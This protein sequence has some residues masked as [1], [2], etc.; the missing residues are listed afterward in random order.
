MC[1]GEQEADQ[2]GLTDTSR[3]D[4]SFSDALSSDVDLLAV[5]MSLSDLC[6]LIALIIR[7]SFVQRSPQSCSCFV[8]ETCK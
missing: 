6:V 3:F 1:R 8:C 4:A 2:V 7:G 5:H